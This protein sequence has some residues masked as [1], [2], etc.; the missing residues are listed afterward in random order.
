M[1]GS[2]WTGATGVIIN[3]SKLSCSIGQPIDK[4][5]PVE[6]L[7]VEIITPSILCFTISF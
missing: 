5:W 4:E 6:P 7:G 3:T 1:D 2:L